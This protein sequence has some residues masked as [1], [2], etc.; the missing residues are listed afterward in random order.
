MLAGLAAGLQPHYVTW[1]EGSVENGWAVALA[2]D[3]GQVRHHKDT[4][5]EIIG[6][7]FCNI[8]YRRH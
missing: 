8:L 3:L 7:N 5:G 4:I 2:G 1:E 6:V